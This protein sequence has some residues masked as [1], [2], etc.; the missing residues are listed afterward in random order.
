MNGKNKPEGAAEVAVA[1]KAEMSGLCE[2][3]KSLRSALR[4]AERSMTG[5]EK[6]A[7][8]RAI[9]TTVRT[10]PEYEAAKTVFA[11]VGMPREI[12]TMDLLQAI[13]DSG[14]RLCVPLCLAEPGKMLLKELTDL[15]ALQPGAYGILEPPAELPTVDP[16]EVD[17]AILPCVSAG[18]DGKRLGQGGGYY[19]RFLERYRGA[20]VLV[21]REALTR[22][23]IPEETHDVRIP[24]VVTDAG[25][26]R[27]GKATD[28]QAEQTT[29]VCDRKA[30]IQ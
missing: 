5:E 15:G 7:A 18:H 3:K 24:L 22:E 23:D 4:C 13:L 27:S 14:R 25:V 6:A 9:C 19:D 1:G 17:L 10:L 11:F 16:A 2:Q 29:E 28:R 8:D 12:Q 21:C 30:E 20:A 26:F